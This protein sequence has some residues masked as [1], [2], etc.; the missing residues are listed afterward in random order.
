GLGSAAAVT[1]LMSSVLFGVSPLDPLT[2][3][4]VAGVIGLVALGASLIPAHRA[5]RLDPARALRQ[6]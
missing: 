1:R 2:F 4:A 6:P 3:A 5:A